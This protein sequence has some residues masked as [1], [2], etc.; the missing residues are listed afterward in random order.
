V[1]QMGQG[2][3][4]EWVVTNS[5][6]T[7]RRSCGDGE[8]TIKWCLDSG[9]AGQKSPVEIQRAQ[10]EEEELT[11]AFGSSSPEDRL[12]V[13]PAFGNLRRLLCNRGR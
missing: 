1:A 13:L 7:P 10:E 9:G 8:N 2:M 12:L 11:G 3:S 4:T 6:W 5:P